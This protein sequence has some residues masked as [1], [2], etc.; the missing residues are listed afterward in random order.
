VRELQ[1][2]ATL[3]LAAGDD[4]T[5]GWAFAEAAWE[6]AQGEHTE[7]AGPL[8]AL[9]RAQWQ[10]IGRP[11]S[12]GSRIEMADAERLF[13]VGDPGGAVQ[14]TRRAVAFDAQARP[15]DAIVAANAHYNLALAYWHAQQLDD[16]SREIDA[17][18]AGA[19]AAV[20]ARHPMVG[21][22]LQLA[23]QIDHARGRIDRAAGDAR[24]SIAIEAAWYGPDD[25]RVDEPT[26][27][28]AEVAA[29]SGDPAE[30]RARLEPLIA[31]QRARDPDLPLSSGSLDLLGIADARAGHCE[32]TIVEAAPLLAK[33]DTP[34]VDPIQV[35]DRLVLFGRCQRELGHLAASL[36][37]LDR[38]LAKA[39]ASLGARAESSVNVAIERG[40]TLVG[41][42]RA[43][44]AV[45]QLEPLLATA[46]DPAFSRPVAA[47]LRTSLADA[48][49]RAGGDRARAR[50]LAGEGLAIY[51]QLGEPFASQRAQTEAW[52][53]AHR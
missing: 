22:F 4:P 39:V 14:A 49:W 44:D 13:H 29:V 51:A 48:L 30:T 1:D 28:L 5:A 19:E 32:R 24:R 35:I 23:S 12:L 25:P 18:I 33:S 16:A 40:Y 2:A 38:G 15:G 45:A 3:A 41:L 42:G 43:N 17:A 50:A 11:R 27:M 6:L 20:G 47:E 36:P 53:A 52:L 21:G 8:L 10:R 37:L 26:L 46:A 9:A 34:G 7:Q 31:R